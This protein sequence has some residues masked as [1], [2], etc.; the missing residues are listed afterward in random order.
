MSIGAG[1]RIYAPDLPSTFGGWPS[2]AA[3]FVLDELLGQQSGLEARIAEL[4]APALDG[5]GYALVRVAVLGRE[6]PTVQIMAEKTGGEAIGINDCE[7][8]SGALGA[9]LDVANP[10]P[11]TWTLEVSSAG[12]DRPLTRRRDWERYAGHLARVEL[13]EP[14]DGRKRVTATI[15]GAEADAALL[16]LENGETLPIPFALMRRARLVLTE[17]LIA[18]TTPQTARH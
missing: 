6:R 1:A 14:V 8:I 2:R 18:A 16:R 5:M 12:I 15:M 13:A 9:V 3:F 10:I 11:G 17:A 4:V 7:A